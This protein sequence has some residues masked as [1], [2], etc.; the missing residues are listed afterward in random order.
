VA[1]AA[2]GGDG[3]WSALAACADGG[4]RRPVRRGEGCWRS[5]PRRLVTFHAP[6]GKSSHVADVHNAPAAFCPPDGKALGE[7]CRCRPPTPVAGRGAG[8]QPAAARPEPSPPEPAGWSARSFRTPVRAAR[9]AERE[10]LTARRHAAPQPP[11]ARGLLVGTKPSSCDRRAGPRSARQVR[12]PGAGGPRG[13]GGRGRQ[14]MVGG[15][16]VMSGA[17]SARMA[18]SAVQGRPLERGWGPRGPAARCGGFP[19]PG[20]RRAC[21]EVT[22]ALRA[23]TRVLHPASAAFLQVRIW[24]GA[25]N[26][27]HAR[28]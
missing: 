23:S 11:D 27:R 3:L 19:H 17:P 15:A 1:R 8:H 13:L 16:G 20:R 22:W 9:P 2:G 26:A 4:P 14:G 24:S 12:A 6:K 21:A 18:G 10:S 25:V 7:R 5:S 28:R